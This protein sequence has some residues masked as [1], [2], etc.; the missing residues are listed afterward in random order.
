M[1]LSEMKDAI[2][3][4]YS[5]QRQRGPNDMVGYERDMSVYD[6]IRKARS[7]DDLA[8]AAPVDWKAAVVNRCHKRDL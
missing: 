6:D 1:K 2:L 5:W 7:W 8:N 3:A 4:D